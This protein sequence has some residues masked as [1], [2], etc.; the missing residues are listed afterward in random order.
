MPSF[1][2]LSNFL[3][4]DEKAVAP[5]Q[6]YPDILIANVEKCLSPNIDILRE[7]GVPVSNIIKLIQSHPQALVARSGRLRKIVEEALEMGFNPKRLMFVHALLAL[8]RLSKS[9]WEC[10][11]DAHKKWGCSEEDVF[12]AFRTSPFC[13]MYSKDQIMASMDFFIN[14]MGWL[15]CLIAKCPLIIGLSLKK[16]VVPRCF[17]FSSFV[18]R[19]FGGEGGWLRDSKKKFLRRFVMPFKTHAADSDEQSFTVSYLIN[20]VG[21]S[22]QSALSASKYVNFESP[23]KPDKVINLF[24]KYGFTQIQISSIV[25]ISPLILSFSAEKFFLPKLEFL[26]AK[27]ISRPEMAKMP[28]VF[29]G[30]LRSNLCKT[31]MPSYE[32]FRDLFQ[33]DEKTIQ[34]VKYRPDILGS[35][36]KYVAPNIAILL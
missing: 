3:H 31:I 19:R 35:V 24:R 27:G 36:E 8:R 13:K 23:E 32:F 34:A 18:V 33:S 9:A 14:Q 25:R 5:F 1:K 21:L 7:H 29:P 11:V 12:N 22:P 28:S 10:K 4:S 26:E 17:G 20:S 2:Y 6:R 15:P 30:L 16:R